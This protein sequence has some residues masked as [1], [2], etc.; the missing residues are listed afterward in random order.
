MNQYISF[1]NLLSNKELNKE[2]TEQEAKIL[3]DQE[4]VGKELQKLYQIVGVYQENKAFIRHV[5]VGDKRPLIL[6]KNFKFINYDCKIV[7][8]IL[9][10]YD[11]EKSIKNNTFK[12][13]ELAVYNESDLF[14]SISFDYEVC[15]IGKNILE[16]LLYKDEI[17]TEG[18]FI[19][20]LNKKDNTKILLYKFDK[21]PGNNN[22]IEKLVKSLQHKEILYIY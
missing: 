8:Y 4:R 11:I 2:M 17:E 20:N 3:L 22:I 16:T 13:V 7:S 21:F 15:K 6:L 14:F 1:E 9:N 18:T 19:I 5:G 12:M 10:K